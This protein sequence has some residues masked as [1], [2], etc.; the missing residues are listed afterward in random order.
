MLMLRCA[1]AL[2]HFRSPSCQLMNS[3]H[4]TTACTQCSLNIVQM[5]SQYYMQV[6]KNMACSSVVKPQSKQRVGALASL[7]ALAAPRQATD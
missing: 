6:R 5:H 2:G 1:D 4:M 3:I 7:H